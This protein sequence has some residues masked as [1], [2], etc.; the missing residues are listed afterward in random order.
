[1]A[2]ILVI[3]DDPT[4]GSEIDRAF[5]QR[6][7]E[8]HI[9]NSLGAASALINSFDYAA[10]VLDLLLPDGHGLTMLDTLRREAQT[11]SVVVVS[12]HIPDYARALLNYYPEVKVVFS[13][14]VNVDSLAETVL[15]IAKT[16]I[17][18]GTDKK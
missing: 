6:D 8:V 12:K 10:I 1:M 9:A 15:A 14:P 18:P 4:F 13:K 7:L 5:R 2:A 16:R 3:D 11:P 17:A